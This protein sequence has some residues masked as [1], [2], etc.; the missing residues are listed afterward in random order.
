MHIPTNKKWMVVSD[1]VTI[2]AFPSRPWS[3]VSLR[4][5]QIVDPTHHPTRILSPGRKLSYNR[6]LSWCSYALADWHR[7]HHERPLV[8]PTTGTFQPWNATSSTKIHMEF[9]LLRLNRI[10]FVLFDLG[11]TDY[12]SRHRW[13]DSIFLLALSLRRRKSW[14]RSLHHHSIIDPTKEIRAGHNTGRL[15]IT[16]ENNWKVLTL[17]LERGD[18][19]WESIWTRTYGEEDKAAILSSWLEKRMT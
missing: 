15:R 19:Y 1:T 10:L 11:Q 2:L 14:T 4:I 5:R 12:V 16:F 6:V 7:V 17:I 8:R 9:L 18:E 3:T 13:V